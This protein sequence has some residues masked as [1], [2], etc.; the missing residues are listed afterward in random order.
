MTKAKARNRKK[1]RL[2]RAIQRPTGPIWGRFLGE[3]FVLFVALAG[4]R[5][6]ISD[7]GFSGKTFYWAGLVAI[8]IA[9]FNEWQ[10]RRK[11]KEKAE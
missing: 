2:E 5:A 10:R 8:A 6:W 1:Q 4:A 3:L 9:S 11:N 7:D